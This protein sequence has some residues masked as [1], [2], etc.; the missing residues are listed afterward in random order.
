MAFFENTEELIRHGIVVKYKEVLAREITQ[1]NYI[2]ALLELSQ[3]I[4]DKI[5]NVLHKRIH[6]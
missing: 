3:F 6:L 5:T 4:H 1:N 2:E